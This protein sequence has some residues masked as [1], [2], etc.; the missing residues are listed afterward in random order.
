MDNGFKKI[1]A[2]GKYLGV[3]T[4]NQA[5][6][7]GVILA[8][9]KLLNYKDYCLNFFLIVNFLLNNL[10]SSIASKILN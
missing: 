5:E 10:I 2:Y 4:N 1:A 7:Q 3:L 6:Y 9:E 8:L